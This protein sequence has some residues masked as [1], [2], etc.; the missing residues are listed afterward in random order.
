M[1]KR[2][3]GSPTA[4]PKAKAKV[5]SAAAPAQSSAAKAKPQPQPKAPKAKATTR[6]ITKDDD[7]LPVA[8]PEEQA[9]N[10]LH[11]QQLGFKKTATAQ[12]YVV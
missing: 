5:A 11:W 3:S 7:R 4:T 12:E 6:K 1:G 8:S 10:R 2:A 9:R